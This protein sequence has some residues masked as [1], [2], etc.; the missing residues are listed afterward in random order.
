MYMRSILLAA[1]LAAADAFSP[2][3]SFAP[4][5]RT[6]TAGAHRTAMA[7]ETDRRSAVRVL[8]GG[9]AAAFVGGAV[10]P[11]LGDLKADAPHSEWERWSLVPAASAYR[12]TKEELLQQAAAIDK[13]FVSMGGFLDTL[14]LVMDEDEIQTSYYQVQQSLSSGAVSGLR[15]TCFHLYRNHVTDPQ[16][17]KEAEVKYKELIKSMEGLNKLALAASRKQLKQEE[18]PGVKT[19]LE[20]ALE[21][22]RAYVKVVEKADAKVAMA[23]AAK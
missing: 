15:M 3:P 17:Y 1:A 11:S 2:A 4:S 7:M 9:A 21:K 19:K 16:Q 14:A 6:P 10:A 12:E 13:A 5:L 8:V 18:L 20:A 23:G 22:L